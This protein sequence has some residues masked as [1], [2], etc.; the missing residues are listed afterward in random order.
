[1]NDPDTPVCY[2]T[3]PKGSWTA[4]SAADI[5]EAKR[6]RELRQQKH[7]ARPAGS[8]I[9]MH[10]ATQ[11]RPAAEVELQGLLGEIALAKLLGLAPE[12]Y[13]HAIGDGI[14]CPCN[15]SDNWDLFGFIDAKT[16]DCS[17]GAPL[18]FGAGPLHNSGTRLPCRLAPVYALMD[19]GNRDQAGADPQPGMRV[20]FVGCC[21]SARYGAEGK[22]VN[23]QGELIEMRG[24]KASGHPGA[25]Y[26][27]IPQATL[28]HLTLQKRLDTR[29]FISPSPVP[30]KYYYDCDCKHCVGFLASEDG[31]ESWRQA[32][33][34]E[35]KT[36][37]GRRA[38][39]TALT[40]SQTSSAAAPA[41]ASELT[42]T[43]AAR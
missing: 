41:A 26:Y 40:M 42:T 43:T 27:C 18:I 39:L 31:Q 19:C 10:A 17:T 30:D 38:F 2:V 5:T 33:G 3:L 16:T 7:K 37:T 13:R 11:T 1:M 8:N 35:P 20:T 12:D 4:L 36:E 21:L 34:P 25:P 15:G 29:E 28:S 22:P 6:L 32:G 24:S 14:A 9:T 23:E